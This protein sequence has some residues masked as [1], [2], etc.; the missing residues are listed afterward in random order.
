MTGIPFPPITERLRV[1]D[2]A[3]T[4]IRSL[5]AN[6]RTTFDGEF[7][8]LKD[9]ILWPKPIQK[10]HPPIIVGG[11]GKGLLRIAAKHA[12]YLNIIAGAGKKGH[13]S[14]DS[15]KKFNDEVYSEKV[16]FVR[17]EAKRNGRSADAV[18]I[19]SFVFITMLTESREAT[20]KTAEQMAQAFGQTPE[21]LLGSPIT[22]IGTPED[23]VVELKRR[24]K[25]WGLSQV[26]SFR[27]ARW[28]RA[29]GKENRFAEILRLQQLPL[30]MTDEGR[31]KKEIRKGSDSSL[32]SRM[33]HGR[34]EEPNPLTR[35][36]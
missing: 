34:R 18:K 16:K 26:I 24:V 20:K 11:G 35:F 1:L 7:Y 2:E 29:N 22:L 3:M 15:V 10:P 30:R 27:F 31:T 19:S 28:R 8:K 21:T 17:E 4:V 23:C 12:D 6:E 32:R 9:A 5:W 13:I 14:L 36:P 25:S 33:T